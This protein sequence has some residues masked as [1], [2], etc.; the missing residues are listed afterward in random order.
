MKFQSI[1]DIK[2]MM[3]NIMVS[4]GSSNTYYN[5]FKWFSKVNYTTTT[6][7]YGELREFLFKV[8]KDN[9]LISF[10]EDL[11][12]LCSVIDKVLSP[13]KGDK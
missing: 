4:I 3:E 10:H 7:Y 6:E 2:L 8:I 11:K 9:T 1:T 5:D 13:S 12:E